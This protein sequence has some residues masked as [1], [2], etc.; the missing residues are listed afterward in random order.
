MNVF[1]FIKERIDILSVLQEHLIL[2]KAG[3]YW[4]G[5]CPF[6]SEKTASFTVS[7]HRGIFYCFGCHE[8]GDVIAFISKIENCSQIEAAKQLAEQ[9]NIDLPETLQL[10][11]TE[12]LDHKKRYFALC[13]L[14][15]R[16]CQQQLQKNPSI[17]LYLE[18][19]SFTQMSIEAYHLGYFAG[20]NSSLR[21]LIQFVSQENF[22][23]K[24]LIEAGIFGESKA[25]YSPFEDRIIFPIKDHLGN[26]CGFGGRIVKKTDERAKYYNSKEHT[27]FQKGSLLF[28]LD[29]AKKAI[30]KSEHV[31][32]VEGYTDCIAMA[33]HGYKNTVAT[34]GTSCTIE[35]LK[36]L[37]HHATTVFIVYDGDK[38]GQK[39][40]MRL[41]ELCWSVN[42][43][44]KV[45]VLPDGDDPASYLTKHGT[46]DK[47][48]ETS[49]DIFLFFLDSIG[50]TYENQSL[51]EKLSSTRAFLQ[52]IAKIQDAFKQDILL[53]KAA[54]IFSLPFTSLKKE[55]QKTAFK[56]KEEHIPDVPSAE[57]KTSQIES[58]TSLEKKFMY[59]ILNDIQLLKRDDVQSILTYLPSPLH[60]ILAKIQHTQ[61]PTELLAFNE[62]FEKLDYHQKQM[63]NQFL[64]SEEGQENFE[65]L[66][67]LLEK[68]YWKTIVNQ[69]KIQLAQAEAEQDKMRVQKIVNSF[70]ELKKKLLRKGLI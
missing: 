23:L 42:L 52:I 67:M 58:Y 53:Q 68:M 69:T 19:R 38:A 64:V 18:Q 57:N 13:A 62:F 48:I 32:L 27:F 22:L 1:S 40:V 45:L 29:T 43:D 49:Q 63:V 47:L 20:G 5:Q 11:P 26:F 2:K 6:H 65:Q 17:K 12:T 28:G 31:F 36:L 41:T 24:D 44:L 16:W 50:S 54:T 34:L 25:L 39:A 51:Q 9:H 55:M 37:S 46:I 4:K 3:G 70:L 10:E 21:S 8:N 60:N 14:V 59:A 30:Q 61:T 7:P 56:H 66:I 35:H 33:Q 15:A